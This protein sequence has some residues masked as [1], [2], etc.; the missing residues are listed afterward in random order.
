VHHVKLRDRSDRCC[1]D[2]SNL[3]ASLR[4]FNPESEILLRSK[5]LRDRCG[6]D[7]SNERKSLRLFN[8]ESE[9]SVR[10][11]KLRDRYFWVVKPL[12]HADLASVRRLR[13][14]SQK[15]GS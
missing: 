1:K 9:I 4:L 2:V 6:K 14:K 11:V 10:H 7:V 13:N 8:L 5:K 12:N 15:F 3:R